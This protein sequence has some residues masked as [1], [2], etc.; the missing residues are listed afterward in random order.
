MKAKL[1][2][3]DVA[4]LA[5]VSQSAVSRAFTPGASVAP[6]TRERIHSAARQLGYR[7]NA[8]ARSLITR[9]SRIIGLVMSYLEN[10]FYPLVIERLS[11]A[12]QRDG[13]HVLLFISETTEADSVL[14][15]I[16]QYQ[17]DG[18][19]MASTTLS[20]ALAND[21]TRAGIPVV[22]FNRVAQ[23]GAMGRY[24]TSSVTS[25]NRAGGRMVGEL[26][27]RTGHRR[28][29]WLAGEENA[30]TSLEREAGLC[31]AL[32]AADKGL[33]A[34]AVGRYD[35]GE[36]QRAVLA[37]FADPATRPDALAVANDHMAIAA[38]ETLR[39]EL[40]LRVPHDVSVVGFDNVPQ[41]AWP[42]FDLTTVQQ[43][44]D[45][46]VDATRALLFEHIG[47]EVVPRSVAVPC[48]LIERG[49][50]RTREPKRRQT[51]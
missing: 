43:D 36:A 3:H 9:R 26:L 19:V 6:E 22:L 50:V 8:I 34:R 32:A 25:Q 47:G 17:V 18:I 35:F 30:S 38:L 5:Q 46:M 48:V 41:A 45:Q 23:M 51:T 27:L 2:A 33:Y 39:A 29:A 15:D 42:S 21:C 12:L 11:Q 49:T 31:E 4:R 10:Q 13:Y 28:I 14:T 24:S 7:P 20:S 1:T 44:V 40:G 37:L 16:L